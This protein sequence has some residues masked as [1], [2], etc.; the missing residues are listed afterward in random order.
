MPV[1]MSTDGNIM[2][3]LVIVMLALAAQTAAADSYSD[4]LTLAKTQYLCEWR[5]AHMPQRDG[6]NDSPP[7][8]GLCDGSSSSAAAA[9][10]DAT[11]YWVFWVA[12]CQGCDSR[13][14]TAWQTEKLPAIRAEQERVAKDNAVAYDA[15]LS[16]SVR[17]MSTD[18][19]C[20]ELSASRSQIAAREL[21]R[22]KAFPA[23][24]LKAMLEGSI[25]IGASERVLRC[26][27]GSPEHRNATVGA[28]GTLVQYVYG[29]TYV[30][31]RNGVV[32]S[33]QT[34]E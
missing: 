2:K 23:A 1:T 16:A 9:D 32:E 11:R 12:R 5:Q 30:Y 22:R 15:R 19:I 26:V 24:D 8:I 4:Q 18:D 3:T 17:A 28:R 21:V 10:S 31:T 7:V 34:F 33:F 14:D 6:D 29:K 27:F 13:F 20:Q 25:R